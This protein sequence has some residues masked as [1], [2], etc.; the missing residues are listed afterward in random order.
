MPG[1]LGDLFELDPAVAWWTNLTGQVLGTPPQPRSYP[2]LTSFQ[3][4]LY[5]F[6]GYRFGEPACL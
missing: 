4:R 3:G 1:F 6:G 5:L 2:G